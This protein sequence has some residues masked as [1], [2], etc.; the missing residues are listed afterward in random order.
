MAKF[1]AV[2]SLVLFLLASCHLQ[3]QNQQ[4]FK[5]NFFAFGTLIEIK[6]FSKSQD[7][8]DKIF[9]QVASKL[10]YM[11]NQWHAWQ[12]SQVTAITAACK[13]QQSV[14]I[15]NDLKK[16]INL[17]KKYYKQSNGL[18]N[19]ASGNLI[20]LW[21]F[22]SSE[23]H[24]S[25]KPPS[26]Q[27]IKDW[28]EFKPSMYDLIIQDQKLTC[29]NSKLALDLGGYAKGYG[30]GKIAS[31]LKKNGIKHAIINAG[32][33]IQTIGSKLKNQPWQISIADPTN[34]KSLMVITSENN[35][36]F[37]SAANIR[38]FTYQNK[39]YHHI[40]NPNTGYPAKLDFL[41]VTVIDKNPTKADAAATTL[42][43][44]GFKQYKQILKN[45][46]I[47]KWIILTKN[48]ELLFS[49]NLK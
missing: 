39:Q 24:I 9:Q 12:P 44:A 2:V 1:K 48:H 3:S 49:E 43:I 23:P 32:G 31:I 46:N 13:N 6:F 4:L 21:G 17:G 27:K 29:H 11:H 34:Q 7:K 28:L 18:F 45:M 33:D 19:P 26:L 22:F 16:L 20:K 14:V 15:D 40:L 37:T 38:K 36:V 10:N 47:K 42:F 41:S 30:V 25:R 5:A 8:A 35:S